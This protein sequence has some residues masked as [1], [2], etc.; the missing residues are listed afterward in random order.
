MGQF[1]EEEKSRE[2]ALDLTYKHSSLEE[3]N[4]RPAAINSRVVKFYSR[5]EAGSPLSPLCRSCWACRILLCLEWGSTYLETP[6]WDTVCSVASIIQG[7]ML[8][9]WLEGDHCSA[10][11]IFLSSEMLKWN[12][13]CLLVRAYESKAG[14]P[15]NSTVLF[16]ENLQACLWGHWVPVVVITE[17]S[18]LG[19]EVKESS[20]H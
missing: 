15:L 7:C 1:T 2:P 3:C 8:V 13:C 9:P 19:G 10:T 14:L 5:S 4:S 12:D 11:S 18:C 6:Q 16:V 20:Q 17:W